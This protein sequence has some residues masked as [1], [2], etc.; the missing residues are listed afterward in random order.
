[1]FK[2]ETCDFCKKKICNDC[3]KSS[4][5]GSK[6]IRKVICKDCWSKMPN[7]K[8]YKATVMAEKAP[9]YERRRY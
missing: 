2:Y 1:M 8:A 9:E 5:K 4:R 6:V 7:R 3:M